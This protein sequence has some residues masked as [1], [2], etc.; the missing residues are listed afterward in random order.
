[1]ERQA[2]APLLGRGEVGRIE[3]TSDGLQRHLVSRLLVERHMHASL[4]VE[5]ERAREQLRGCL[6]IVR[7]RMNRSQA[8]EAVEHVLNVSLF[9]PE[10]R[11]G[12]DMD[13]PQIAITEGQFGHLKGDSEGSDPVHLLDVKFGSET[14]APP[15]KIRANLQQINHPAKLP[16]ITMMNWLV[17][18]EQRRKMFYTGAG[19]N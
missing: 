19:A 16:P 14:K 9:A 5:V 17:V 15:S 13:P 10:L 11:W 8:A 6:E 3:A 7:T 4:L 1:M 12:T 18:I 2:L